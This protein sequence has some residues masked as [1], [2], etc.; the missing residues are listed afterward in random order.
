MEKLVTSFEFLFRVI[1]VC[2]RDLYNNAVTIIEDC[3][4]EGRSLSR[5]SKVGEI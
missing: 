2:A 3:Q 5:Q 1:S 4:R